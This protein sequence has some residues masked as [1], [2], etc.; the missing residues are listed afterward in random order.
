MVTPDAVRIRLDQFL[1]SRIP[2]ESRSQ[3]QNWIRK[4]HLIVNGTK[5]KTGY[6]THL[7]DRIELNI[8]EFLP[9]QPVP[10]E[11]PLNILYEDSDLAVINKPAGLVC[12]AGA[13]VRSGTLVNALLHHM[14][15]LET[16]DPQRP[17]IVHRLDKLTSGVML[18]ARNRPAHR[19]LSQQFKSREV[20]KEYVALVHGKP[21]PASGTIDMPLGRD[22]KDRKR[23]SVR[24]RKARSA[25][26]HY[27]LM[28]DLGPVSL[29]SVRIET[30]RT[31]QIRVHLAQKGHPVVG[32]SV[33]GAGK[34]RGLPPKILAAAKDLQRPFLHS[35]RI[36][37]QHPGSGKIMEFSAPLPIELVRFLSVVRQQS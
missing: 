17:G 37:F 8:P 24:A 36:Q 14:G 35:Q 27:S 10:E 23:I 33:Y 18:V 5:V 34:I 2:G 1:I 32:D 22:P 13:G 9:D 28:E 16:G 4:G 7:K 6:R 19:L 20:K 30:G 26:T 31:H 21:V 12:H 25:I 3:I 29:L 15:P 11:I